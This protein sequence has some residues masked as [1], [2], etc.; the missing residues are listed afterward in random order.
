MFK[1]LK[2][3]EEVSAAITAVLLN[4]ESGTWMGCGFG[5]TSDKETEESERVVWLNNDSIIISIRLDSKTPVSK[6][7]AN[8]L[9]NLLL[10]CANIKD[11][12][13][14]YDRMIIDEIIRLLKKEK[15]VTS[16]AYKNDDFVDRF[17]SMVEGVT[18]V[19]KGVQFKVEGSKTYYFVHV[20]YENLVKKINKKYAVTYLKGIDEYA[21]G[22]PVMERFY[23]TKSPIATFLNMVK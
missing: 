12:A 4:K 2:T 17:G 22:D 8:K 18:Y 5:M 13:S 14:L 6:K 7:V 16:I 3:Q 23:Y 9:A 11:L 10:E 19:V 1:E 21:I 20:Y 15:A